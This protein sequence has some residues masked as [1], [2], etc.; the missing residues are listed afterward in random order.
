MSAHKKSAKEYI[1]MFQLEQIDPKV[2]Y[3][4]P[5]GTSPWSI[6]NPEGN[7]R[8]CYSTIYYLQTQG[9]A[10]KLHLLKSD[11]V[12]FYHDGV[13]LTVAYLDQTVPGNL[14]KLVLGPDNPQIRI[15]SGKYRCQYL[16][17]QPADAF[18]FLSVLVSPGFDPTDSV[19][20][21]AQ[22]LMKM[23]PEAADFIQRFT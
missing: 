14:V 16:D 3:M 4:R 23:F 11:E 7:K 13:P 18:T 5:M 1:E 12:F 2:G 9:Q 22:D 10:N 17:S 15:A 8:V 19:D 6:S 21:N 20:G